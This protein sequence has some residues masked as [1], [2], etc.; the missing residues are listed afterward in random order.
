MKSKFP[1]VQVRRSFFFN[2]RYTRSAKVSKDLI[3][4]ETQPNKCLEKAR[5]LSNYR[6]GYKSN[7][8]YMPAIC[9]HT[10]FTFNIS[11]SQEGVLAVTAW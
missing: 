1:G 5:D 7:T 6:N 2:V 11:N 4:K 3:N 10:F 8:Q 9:S